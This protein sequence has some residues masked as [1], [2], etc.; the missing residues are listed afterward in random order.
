MTNQY[1]NK[2]LINRVKDSKCVSIIFHIL[3][4]QARIM[5]LHPNKSNFNYQRSDLA[6]IARKTKSFNSIHSFL[7]THGVYNIIEK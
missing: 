3:V 6:E 4:I 2:K 1:I 7:I 5:A